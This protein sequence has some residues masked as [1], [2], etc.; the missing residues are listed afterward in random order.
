[1][2]AD[3]WPAVEA[4]GEGV[5]PEEVAV[6]EPGAVVELG[7]EDSGAWCMGIMET[8]ISTSVA[9]AEDVVGSVSDEHCDFSLLWFQVVGVYSSKH[10]SNEAAWFEELSRAQRHQ[11]CSEGG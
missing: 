3:V 4:V 7:L 1:M 8:G 6:A 9:M 11:S 5:R 10:D 2:L